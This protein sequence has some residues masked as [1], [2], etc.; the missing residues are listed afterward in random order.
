MLCILIAPLLLLTIPAVAQVNN[1]C[2]V[3]RQCT[4]DEEWDKGYYAFQNGQCAAP[5]DQQQQASSSSQPTS[6]S[7]QAEEVD[8]CCFEDWQCTTDTQWFIGYHA[9]QYNQCSAPVDVPRQPSSPT[10]EES[11]PTTEASEVIDNCCQV[12]RL[13]PDF[14]DWI[15][16]YRAFRR[17]QCA[18]P[19]VEFPEDY[20]SSNPIDNCCFINRTCKTNDAW[21]SGYWA[22]KANREC[23]A[24]PRQQQGQSG[25]RQ[26]Q[27]QSGNQQQGQGTS[28]TPTF[29][30]KEDLGTRVTFDRGDGTTRTVWKGRLDAICAPN[31]SP[32]HPVCQ[33]YS[34]R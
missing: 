31:W 6:T 27:G 17:N 7:A 20:D 29:T 8:N 33:A 9:F 23:T 21:E 1:C 3:D 10:Q 25:N 19:P 11:Q 24:R 2:S 5:A 34:G 30:L 15:K 16:G 12:D 28:S 22:Y 32:N 14:I 18:G 26:Q 13:C 4:T